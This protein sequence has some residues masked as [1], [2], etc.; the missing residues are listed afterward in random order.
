MFFLIAIGGLV[1]SF[2]NGDFNIGSFFEGLEVGSWEAL[3]DYVNLGLGF[4][5]L[6]GVFIF[7]VVRAARDDKDY[8][9]DFEEDQKKTMI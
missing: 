6:A 5:V 9:W 7:F 4:L 2:L 1:I 3:L 8:Y